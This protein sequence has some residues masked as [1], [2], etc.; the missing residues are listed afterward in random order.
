LS[1]HS[2]IAQVSTTCRKLAFIID[3]KPRI[4]H[5]KREEF[6]PTESVKD[7]TGKGLMQA[8]EKHGFISILRWSKLTLAMFSHPHIVSADRCPTPVAAMILRGI[9]KQPSTARVGALTYKMLLVGREQGR[10]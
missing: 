2:R 7:R 10:G 3:S 9:H 1:V 8:L 4:V 5:I 6:N